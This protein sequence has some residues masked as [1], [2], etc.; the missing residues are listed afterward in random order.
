MTALEVLDKEIVNMRRK[1]ADCD[2]QLEKARALR[3]YDPFAAR[4]KMI[5]LNHQRD[6][7]ARR[8]ANLEYEHRCQQGPN[9]SNVG[10]IFFGS[11]S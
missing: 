2:A 1:I 3:D 10:S 5:P 4:Q 6:A 7:Y 9:V 8:L 11:D